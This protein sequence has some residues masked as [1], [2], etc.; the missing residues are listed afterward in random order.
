MLYRYYAQSVDVVCPLLQDVVSPV[1]RCG[2]PAQ[3]PIP[4]TPVPHLWAGSP[5]SLKWDPILGF[6]TQFTTSGD[7]V[8]L[9]SAGRTMRRTY[10]F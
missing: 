2:A 7:R 6:C 4:C 10:N 9:L 8:P 5:C 3:G 1:A